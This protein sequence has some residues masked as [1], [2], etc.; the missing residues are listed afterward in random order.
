MHCDYSTVY[1]TTTKTRT[2]R[3]RKRKV[4]TTGMYALFV[5]VNCGLWNRSIACSLFF[6]F[7]FFCFVPSVTECFLVLLGILGG[8]L[9]LFRF[10]HHV[11]LEPLIA[12]PYRLALSTGCRL[13]GGQ[14]AE[15]VLLSQTDLDRPATEVAH[16]HVKYTFGSY[17]C[18]WSLES[19]L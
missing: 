9:V 7:P 10:S 1:P 6:F 17:C 5:R 19:R 14:F 12:A 16:I 11:L 15:L 4:A 3:K 8:L 2:L 18:F 13:K